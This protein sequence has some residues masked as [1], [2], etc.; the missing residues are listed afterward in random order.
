VSYGVAVVD[1]TQPGYHRGRVPASKVKAF[2]AEILTSDKVRA[3][4]AQCSTTSGSGIRHRALIV[5]LSRTGLRITEALALRPNYVNLEIGSVT[6]LHGKGDRLRTV[7]ID[8]GANI[9]NEASFRE[10]SAR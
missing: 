10:A 6:V 3:L 4:L 8:S 7:G 9:P 1:G 2:P 5:L